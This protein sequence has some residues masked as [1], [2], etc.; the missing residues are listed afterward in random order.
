MKRRAR[1]LVRAIAFALCLTSKMLA[2]APSPK[3]VALW[4]DGAPA[5]AGKEE[6]DV[7][8]L[9][10]YLP[11]KSIGTSLIVFPGGGYVALAMDHEGKQV[12]EWLNSYGIAAFVLKYRLAPRYRHP[13]PL[14][15]AQRA[16]R[17]VR[18]H[19]REWGLSPDRIGVLGFS[20]GGHLA[21]TTGTHFDA[22]NADAA[23]PVERMSSR[24]D[25]LVL[26]YPVISFT[27]PFSHVGSRRSLLGDAP[28]PRLLEDLS[29]EK[30]VTP[31]TP[32]TFLFHTTE[33]RV[34]PPE[35]SIAFYLALR[36]AGVPAELH[37]YERGQHGVGLAPQDQ[38]LATWKDR[39][40][41]WMKTRGLFPKENH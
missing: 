29:N 21:A 4:P 30:R 16:I 27:A 1:H 38:I 36:K 17:Y 15:D 20:A 28:D 22:G 5:A 33:D 34:V 40:I 12:A 6:K 39:L 31:Q 2:Q 23:D 24:P 19:A 14:Q 37:I 10:I 32:P 9:A 11:P 8:T 18:F 35:N 13:A 7:P 26:A 25:F 3:V 41:D